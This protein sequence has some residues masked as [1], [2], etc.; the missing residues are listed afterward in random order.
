[1]ECREKLAKYLVEI[2]KHYDSR[3]DAALAIVDVIDGIKRQKD[4]ER[5]MAIEHLRTMRES[6]ISEDLFLAEL[7]ESR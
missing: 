2:I 5:E 1:M 3:K 4:K 7:E 6:E